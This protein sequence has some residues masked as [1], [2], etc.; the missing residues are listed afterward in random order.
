MA[1]T[2]FKIVRSKRVGSPTQKSVL[3]SIVLYL[4]EECKCR[5]SIRQIMG[6]T[7]LGRTATYDAIRNLKNRGLI[8]SDGECFTVRLEEINALPGIRE[9]DKIIRQTNNP[10]REANTLVRE[11]DKNRGVRE[12]NHL[13]NQELTDQKNSSLGYI[14]I[15]K[16]IKEQPSQAPAENK[17]QKIV[18]FLGENKTLYRLENKQSG[19][20]HMCSEK[21][22]NEKSPSS[23]S[24]QTKSAHVC[25][26]LPMKKIPIG[27]NL[28]ETLGFVAQRQKEQP[29]R[30][31]RGN[32]NYPAFH[33]VLRD[34]FKSH[35]NEVLPPFCAKDRGILKGLDAK[36][37][38]NN[39]DITK[40]L[41]HCVSHWV[42][43]RMFVMDRYQEQIGQI[44]S[45]G[46]VSANVQFV[47][48]FLLNQKAPA[49]EPVQ[50]PE[51]ETTST[52]PEGPS[53]EFQKVLDNLEPAITLEEL[54]KYL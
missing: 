46:W 17:D 20:A 27:K 48:N 51:P 23:E 42:Q 34:I 10:V 15:Y 7:E 22:K 31:T 16:D 21:S 26:V 47:I 9:T 6:D 25:K 14:G 8:Y 29:L 54:E 41:A 33:R 38:E 30:N 50:A 11:A 5:R 13:I 19:G 52:Q 4:N 3:L 45:I 18:S 35:F 2:H 43:L 36:F 40:E 53:P 12:K 39:L 24:K 28:N 49:A 32:I 37:S 44:P 1:F